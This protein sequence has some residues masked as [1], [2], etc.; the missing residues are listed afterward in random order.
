MLD[1]SFSHLHLFIDGIKD[2][3][4]ITESPFKYYTLF[5]TSTIAYRMA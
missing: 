4:C 1:L 3:A 2:D 5:R